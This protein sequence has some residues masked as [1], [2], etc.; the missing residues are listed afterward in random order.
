M[1]C[2]IVTNSIKTFKKMVCIK[3][4][5]KKER[6]EYFLKQAEKEGTWKACP[7]TRDPGS[8]KL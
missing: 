1:V 6:I 5:L 8:P 2:S 7:L 3:K 4:N